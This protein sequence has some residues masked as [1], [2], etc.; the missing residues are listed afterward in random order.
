M[1]NNY[2]YPSPNPHLYPSYYNSH[3]TPYNAYIPYTPFL[4]L[5]ILLLS[6]IPRYIPFD[7]LHSS[8]P[9]PMTGHTEAYYYDRYRRLAESNKIN[10]PNKYHYDANG[11]IIDSKE[12]LYYD[13][14]PWNQPSRSFWLW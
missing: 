7:P 3:T 13:N 4:A 6:T 11:D 9:I 2:P 10:N 1:Y 8:Y 14:Q 5:L 12:A